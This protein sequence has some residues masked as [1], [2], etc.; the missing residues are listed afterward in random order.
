MLPCRSGG[1]TGLAGE[2]VHG[3]TG[4]AAAIVLLAVTGNE[5]LGARQPVGAG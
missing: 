5:Q 2:P 1:I 3:G 4:P